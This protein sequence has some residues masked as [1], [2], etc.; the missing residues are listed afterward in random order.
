MGLG[1]PGASQQSQ[2]VRPASSTVCGGLGDPGMQAGAS[3]AREPGPSH[4]AAS[5][6]GLSTQAR[7]P[8]APPN[9][10][11]LWTLLRH[12]LITGCWG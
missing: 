7:A 1:I 5:R 8:S 9:Q 3:C 11:V 12:L 10:C 4:Q 2:Q 6:T